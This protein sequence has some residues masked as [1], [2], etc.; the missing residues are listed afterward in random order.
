[1]TIPPSRTEPTTTDWS[2]FPLERSARI[3]ASIDVDPE[4]A[5]S[6]L[7]AIELDRDGWRALCGHWQSELSADAGRGSVERLRVFDAV[8]VA[9][10]E[11]ERG[12]ITPEEYARIIVATERGTLPTA[13]EELG[14]P[15]AAQ[16][17]VERQWIGRMTANAE[18]T[19]AVK[20]AIRDERATLVPAPAP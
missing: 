17:R 3:A 14:I 5:P 1:M 12:A 6:I 2:A 16:V 7:D 10:L 20:R 13:L 18:L 4:A 9:R 15:A 11:E 19:R 8:Y